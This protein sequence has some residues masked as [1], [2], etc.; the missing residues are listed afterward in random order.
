MVGNGATRDQ[1]QGSSLEA[2]WGRPH[3]SSLAIVQHSH[4]TAGRKQTPEQLP[5]KTTLVPDPSKVSISMWNK[6]PKCLHLSSKMKEEMIM[7]GL[8]VMFC[9]VHPVLLGVCLEKCISFGRLVSD[10]CVG[11]DLKSSGW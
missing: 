7:F 5:K 4:A 9:L 1:A 8:K 6:I 3:Q 11:V 2:S 10:R